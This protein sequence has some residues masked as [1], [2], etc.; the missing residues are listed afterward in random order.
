MNYI[1]FS[2]DLFGRRLSSTFALLAGCSLATFRYTSENRNIGT[3][4]ELERA[5]ILKN[6]AIT[7]CFYFVSLQNVYF[8]KKT[9]PPRLPLTDND[10][11]NNN[12]V[13]NIS[14]FV[15]HSLSVTYG[16]FISY[17]IDSYFTEY[18]YNMRRL[19]SVCISCYTL[20]KGI[21]YLFK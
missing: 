18:N 1:T 10:E 3:A 14:S 19:F 21:N 7:I 2:N 8:I 17:L 4:D 13:N 9:I 11:H 6:I 20:L 5:N 15:A 12:V 16:Y